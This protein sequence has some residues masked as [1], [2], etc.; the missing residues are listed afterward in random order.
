[1]E[2]HSCT[3]SS[4]VSNKGYNQIKLKILMEIS[5]ICSLIMLKKGLLKILVR[6]KIM[7]IS[8]RKKCPRRKFI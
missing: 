5:M 6:M 1:M 8:K 2:T 3:N 7:M 4:Q